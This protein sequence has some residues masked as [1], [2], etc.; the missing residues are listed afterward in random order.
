MA[1]EQEAKDSHSPLK[2]HKPKPLVVDLPKK[3]F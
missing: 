2:W 3:V 1:D